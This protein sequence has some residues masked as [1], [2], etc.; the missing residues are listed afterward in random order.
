MPLTVKTIEASKSKERPYRI[1]DGNGLYLEVPPTGAKRW[2]YRFRYAGKENMISLG[3]YPDVT[4]KGTRKKTRP[5]WK[6]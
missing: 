4:L 5:L 3:T 1:G 2:R 6:A